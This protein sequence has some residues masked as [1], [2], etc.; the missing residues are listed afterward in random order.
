MRRSSR[1]RLEIV[2]AEEE[3]GEGGRSRRSS[4]RRGRTRTE[5]KR[6]VRVAGI[7]LCRC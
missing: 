7:N 1:E 3:M 6:E 2:V 5:R 4:E